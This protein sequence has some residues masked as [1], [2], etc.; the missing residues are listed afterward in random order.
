MPGIESFEVENFAVQFPAL[1][2]YD[3]MKREEDYGVLVA[4]F[5]P[6]PDEPRCVVFP[7]A[8]S[9]E[10]PEDALFWIEENGNS[11]LS[12]ERVDDTVYL[13]SPRGE[14]VKSWKAEIR[15]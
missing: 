9:F 12:A 2:H 14:E 5:L 15:E 4:V 10:A 6:S 8:R 11:F 13:L 1:V 3:V 7:V